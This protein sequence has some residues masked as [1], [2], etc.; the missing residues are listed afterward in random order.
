MGLANWFGVNRRKLQGEPNYN[1]WQRWSKLGFKK[2]VKKM[3]YPADRKKVKA[4]D[5]DLRSS[6][7]Q[8]I[9]NFQYNKE[10]YKRHGP[11]F[12]S[13]LKEQVLTSYGQVGLS[14]AAKRRNIAGLRYERL[15]EEKEATSAYLEETKPSFANQS[16]QGKPVTTASRLGA[17]PGQVIQK[18]SEERPE[19]GRDIISGKAA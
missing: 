18:P 6:G 11:K 5:A 19:V 13:R 2:A 4:L 10:A 17:T 3:Q 16:S 15:R 12:K 8:T 9:S 7:R 14:P 1:K